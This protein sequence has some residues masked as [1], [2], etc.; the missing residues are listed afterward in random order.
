MLVPVVQVGTPPAPATAPT[1]N[2]TLERLVSVTRLSGSHLTRFFNSLLR[3]RRQAASLGGT[4]IGAQLLSQL[5]TSPQIG[6]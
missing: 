6:S 5:A 3:E 1:Q 2:A 4:S